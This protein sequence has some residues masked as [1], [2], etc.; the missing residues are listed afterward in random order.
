MRYLL[1]VTEKKMKISKTAFVTA[2]REQSIVDS[3]T[4]KIC[5]AQPH[6][7]ISIL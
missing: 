2:Q 6:T 1:P 4:R 7:N 5:G 3:A